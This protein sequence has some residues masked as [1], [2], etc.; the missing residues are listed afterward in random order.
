MNKIIFLFLSCIIAQH[1]AYAV[2]DGSDSDSEG[3]D[4]EQVIINVDWAKSVALSE[5][6][7]CSDGT[8]LHFA[9]RAGRLDVINILLDLGADPNASGTGSFISKTP[10]EEVFEGFV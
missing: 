10:L 4:E 3:S 5:K 8:P 9:V 6:S 1:I 7:R 2:R